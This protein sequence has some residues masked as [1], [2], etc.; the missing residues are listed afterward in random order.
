MLGV[1][2]EK[3]VIQNV[4]NV[5]AQVKDNFDAYF[6]YNGNNTDVDGISAQSDIDSIIS[7]QSSTPYWYEQI[8]HQGISA[9]GPSG[10]AVYRNVKDY[11]ATGK[12]LPLSAYQ[13]YPNSA[14]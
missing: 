4:E 1:S 9:F 12:F 8:A 7:R 14:N 13:K 5:V 6:S 11:G 10:Y 2:C 3:L